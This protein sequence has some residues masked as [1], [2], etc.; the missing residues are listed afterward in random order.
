M[1]CEYKL[2]DVSENVI[3]V[4]LG[5]LP[6]GMMV[7]VT[8]FVWRGMD[9]NWFF[10]TPGKV[11]WPIDSMFWTL[12]FGCTAQSSGDYELPNHV[13]S[14]CGFWYCG[15]NYY[16]SLLRF[17]INCF[18]KQNFI[19]YVRCSSL[20]FALL[21]LS[22][23]PPP[24]RW[25]YKVMSFVP[26]LFLMIVVAF[27]IFLG[28]KSSSC[29]CNCFTK[30]MEYVLP[31]KKVQLWCCNCCLPWLAS[32]LDIHPGKFGHCIAES[33]VCSKL[34]SYAICYA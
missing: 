19:L 27:L 31:S 25:S 11:G 24:N 7:N 18:C 33:K 1:E 14:T 5:N 21:S 10:Q 4:L 9:G 6:L 2:V 29:H 16:N 15:I 13:V 17:C 32:E 3:I 28:G 22:S 20:D 26:E 8:G 12:K 34:S 30:W 23:P